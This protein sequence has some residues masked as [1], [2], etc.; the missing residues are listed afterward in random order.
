M[1]KLDELTKI[2]RPYIVKALHEKKVQEY[3]STYKEQNHAEPT[4]GQLSYFISVIIANGIIVNETDV[5]I[6]EF[7]NEIINNYR[8]LSIKNMIFSDS[9]LMLLVFGL[10]VNNILLFMAKH[11][12][13]EGLK[14][15]YFTH[16]SILAPTIILLCL[17]L[18]HF[19]SVLT[20]RK[21]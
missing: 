5:F 13:F 11:L 17:S 18:Y 16:P 12:N 3:I 6:K 20:D 8:S 10:S 21:K 4:E 15:D 9:T 2:L 19:Y 14:E 1:K 7:S